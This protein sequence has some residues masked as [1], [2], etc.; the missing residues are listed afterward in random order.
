MK[1]EFP[2][3]IQYGAGST[4]GIS[5]GVEKS[6]GNTAT[7]Q[8]QPEASRNSFQ[9]RLNE[10]VID[11]YERSADNAAVPDEREGIDRRHS[12]TRRQSSQESPSLQ[13]SKKVTDADTYSTGKKESQAYNKAGNTVPAVFSPSGEKG[14]LVD[15]FA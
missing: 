3:P 10:I 8:A 12:S 2:L 9:T 6:K 11:V 5:N 15:I 13:S 7:A 4:P 1:S 14:R